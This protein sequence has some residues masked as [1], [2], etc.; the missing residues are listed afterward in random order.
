ME[1]QPEEFNKFAYE[2]LSKFLG[3]FNTLFTIDF[4]IVLILT[5]RTHLLNTYEVR[6]MQE[7]PIQLFKVLRA[8]RFE[9]NV[10]ILVR[11]LAC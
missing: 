8:F 10:Q 5:N 11:K 6:C 4:H 1:G 3:T 2:V 9:E 7:R